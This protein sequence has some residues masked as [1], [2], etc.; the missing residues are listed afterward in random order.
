MTAI[1]AAAAFAFWDSLAGVG[2]TWAAFEKFFMRNLTS[3]SVKTDLS[4]EEQ[5]NLALCPCY[6]FPWHI[7]WPS[8]G[9][10]DGDLSAA[11]R[12]PL[13]VRRKCLSLA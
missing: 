12:A 13:A 3:V 2:R 6:C 7:P 1:G 9:Q 5:T 4:M 8:F 11:V 10:T